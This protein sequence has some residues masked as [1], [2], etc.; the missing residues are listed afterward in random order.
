MP[1]LR[2]H[3]ISVLALGGRIGPTLIEAYSEP[4]IQLLILLITAT[5]FSHQE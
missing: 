3:S 4:K 1:A 2:S 5:N